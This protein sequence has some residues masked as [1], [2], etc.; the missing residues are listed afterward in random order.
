MSINNDIPA[1]AK[2][3]NHEVNKKCTFSMTGAYAYKCMPQMSF[4][5]LGLIVV[6]KP[7]NLDKLSY[8]SLARRAHDHL[9]T[10]AQQARGVS[11]TVR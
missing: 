5:M 11:T 2:P 3:F 9:A 1:S 4:G 10:L 8:A 6:N 7:T